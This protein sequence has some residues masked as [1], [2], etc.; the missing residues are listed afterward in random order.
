MR[1]NKRWS[2]CSPRWTVPPRHWR[3]LNGPE[4]LKSCQEADYT[5]LDCR[6][7]PAEVCLFHTPPLEDPPLFEWMRA[8]PDTSPLV[9]VFPHHMLCC[10]VTR[11]RGQ[12]W[13]KKENSVISPQKGNVNNSLNLKSVESE[14]PSFSFSFFPATEAKLSLFSMFSFALYFVFCFDKHCFAKTL[15]CFLLFISYFWT[16]CLHCV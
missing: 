10:K 5:V 4:D 15:N 6:A 12:I 1:L 9:F 7:S 2:P 3:G 8:E 14:P 16:K 13:K 11:V